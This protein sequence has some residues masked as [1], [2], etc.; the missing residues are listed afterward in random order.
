MT[1]GDG[2]L[3][4]VTPGPQGKTAPGGFLLHDPDWDPTPFAELPAEVMVDP[5]RG[6][7][8]E[9]LERPLGEPDEMSEDASDR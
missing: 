3:I 4:C 5:F 2:Q 9:E 1:N 6:G 7:A 8:G